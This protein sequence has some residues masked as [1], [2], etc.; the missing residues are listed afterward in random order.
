[1]GRERGAPPELELRPRL[2]RERR[3]T[4]RELILRRGARR[5]FLPVPEFELES[6]FDLMRRGDCAITIAALHRS[7]SMLGVGPRY[8][9][10][11][12]GPAVIQ[13]TVSLS[14]TQALSSH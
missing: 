5:G 14:Q 4:G 13:C 6:V 12:W 1:M 2:D 7:S 10:I 3:R 9:N 8:F 11:E